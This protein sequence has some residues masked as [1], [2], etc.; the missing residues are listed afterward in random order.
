L[1]LI[2]VLLLAAAITGLQLEPATRPFTLWALLFVVPVST[3]AGSWWFFK[4]DSLK[5]SLK[6]LLA[7]YTVFNLLFLAIA[8]PAV[9]RQN[10]VTKTL[11]LLQKDG[12]V[13]SYKIYNAAFNFYL[14]K[15]IKMLDDVQ[16]VKQLVATH[17]DAVIISRENHLH[18]LDSIP[19][20]LLAKERDLFE[21]ATT[22]VLKGK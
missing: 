18:D 11:H 20:T 19:L 3:A 22:V 4:K 8:Y 2:N 17:P 6:I 10:P 14:S 1:L 7:G 9:Y 13:Y 15:P 12:Q 21:T 5:K 16:Q